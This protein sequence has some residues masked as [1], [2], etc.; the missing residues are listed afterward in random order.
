MFELF[1]E[2]R[3][4]ILADEM[5]LGKTVQVKWFDAKYVYYI[6]LWVWY[7]NLSFQCTAGN[8]IPSRLV[9]FS[10]GNARTCAFT[11]YAHKPVEITSN[12][13]VS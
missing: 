11:S 2:R 10:L 6:L 9:Q 12:E 13:V 8:G 5:G 3:G 1:K 7:G 4:G